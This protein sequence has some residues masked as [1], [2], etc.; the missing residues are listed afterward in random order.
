MEKPP[1]EVHASIGS[2]TVMMAGGQLKCQAKNADGP[3]RDISDWS[4][5][6]AEDR[7]DV[8]RAVESLSPS[9]P[10]FMSGDPS[11]LGGRLRWD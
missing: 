6:P 4:Q 2:Y 3:P 11:T 5:L 8:Q 9:L 10:P 7:Q 1:I